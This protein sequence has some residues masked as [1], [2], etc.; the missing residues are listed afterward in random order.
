MSTEKCCDFAL[1]RRNCAKKMCISACLD[2]A[3]SDQQT[4]PVAQGQQRCL[5]E[6]T[7]I[8]R[9]PLI[10]A[11]RGLEQ[12]RI[13]ADEAQG[14]CEQVLHIGQSVN[15]LPRVDA[16]RDHGRV[17]VK[18]VF[19]PLLEIGAG[20]QDRAVSRVYRQ[21]AGE[22]FRRGGEQIGVLRGGS[23]SR[24]AWMCAAVVPQQ[25]PKTAT[26]ASSIAGT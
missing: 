6:R 2:G 11:Q 10:D 25:P 22:L 23:A 19:Q 5:R 24:S 3:R 21:I 15:I 17:A 16:Q 14:L 18:R 26:P 9:A 7:L 13:V 20:R 1:S 8:Q 12:I 4:V